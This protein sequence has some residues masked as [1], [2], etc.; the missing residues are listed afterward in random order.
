[1]AI[2]VSPTVDTYYC[3]TVA[4][5]SQ[6]T[7]TACVKI[8]VEEPNIPCPTNKDLSLPDAFSPNNDRNNDVFCL[9]GWNTCVKNFIVHIYDRWGEEVFQ[10]LDPQFCWDGTYK[11]KPLDAAV[12]VYYIEAE[13][14]TS[15]KVVR[16]GNISLIR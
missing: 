4:D 7:D 13:L 15:E 12:F 3:V 11:G 16:K 8:F 9:Q 5:A 10:S 2:T 6:C 14:T 1:P